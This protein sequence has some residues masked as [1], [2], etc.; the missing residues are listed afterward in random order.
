[1]AISPAKAMLD[2]LQLHAIAS[3]SH[4]LTAQRRMKAPALVGV[5]D[6]RGHFQVKAVTLSLY[7][8]ITN[9]LDRDGPTCVKSAKLAGKGLQSVD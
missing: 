8:T 3:N 5:G 2:A 9:S 4:D 7:G 1:M 6:H